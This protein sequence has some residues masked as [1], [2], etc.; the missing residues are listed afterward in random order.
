[1]MKKLTVLILFG[2]VSNE[3]YVS[4]RSA[5]SVIA[6]LDRERFEPVLVGITHDGRW[7]LYEGDTDRILDDTWMNGATP[8]VLSP[9]RSVHGLVVFDEAGA[10]TVRI[11]V[12]FPVVHGQHCEDGALQGLMEL[13]GIPYVGPH[14][15][16]AAVT[17]DKAITHI[18]AENAGIPMA[19]WL[20]VT[21]GEDFSQTARRVQDSFGYP[22]FVK[23]ANSGSSVG[24]SGAKNEQELKAALETAFHEDRRVLIEEHITA[25]E[26]ECAVLGNDELFAPRTGE[27]VSNDGFYDFDS[28]YLNDSARLFIPALIPEQVSAEVCALAKKTYRALDCRGLARVDFFVKADNTVLLNEINTLPGFTSISMFPKMM[29]DAGLSYPQLIT[30]L[31]ELAMEVDAV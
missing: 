24:C 26:V 3:Y 5:A 13:S 30:R 31:L 16:A 27:I 2:G 22:C 15:T 19:K 18:V 28:K 17:F 11:D 4:R 6:E 25:H 14:V 7:F 10:R 8:A 12:I 29:I 1:M 20:L 23:P 21:K 9:D